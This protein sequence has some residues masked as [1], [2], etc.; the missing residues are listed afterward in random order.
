MYQHLFSWSLL[1][2]QPAFQPLPLKP[3]ANVFVGFFFFAF[4]HP[5][6]NFPS[7]ETGSQMSQVLV[8]A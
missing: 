4:S 5:S 1:S 6:F 8:T 7:R 2:S 3:T